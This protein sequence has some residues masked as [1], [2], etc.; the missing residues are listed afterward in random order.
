MFSGT[1]VGSASRP[2]RQPMGNGAS[3]MR[4]DATNATSREGSA[5]RRGA[6]IV[7]FNGYTFLRGEIPEK[8]RM[9]IEEAVRAG[10]FK[11][12]LATTGA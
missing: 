1:A 9:V 12:P 6:E 8:N 4:R 2:K 11:P 10:F 7:T 5:R 3:G